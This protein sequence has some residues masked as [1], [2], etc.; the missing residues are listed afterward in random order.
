MSAPHHVTAYVRYQYDHPAAPA[1]YFNFDGTASELLD[2]LAIA[3]REPVIWLHAKIRVTGFR[4]RTIELS[5]GEV[6][7]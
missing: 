5:F 6:P 3:T 2:A 4:A 7:S 1:A